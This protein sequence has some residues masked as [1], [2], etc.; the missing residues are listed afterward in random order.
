MCVSQ[1]RDYCHAS[2]FNTDWGGKEYQKDLED[3]TLDIGPYFKYDNMPST[4]YVTDLKQM[5]ELAE[6]GNAYA[7]EHLKNMELSP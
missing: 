1:F 6:K 3:P 4:Y 7:I 2:R 5:K